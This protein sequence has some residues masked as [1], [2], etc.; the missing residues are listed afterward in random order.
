MLR[1][2]DGESCFVQDGKGVDCDDYA[3]FSVQDLLE[4]VHHRATFQL[5]L[6]CEKVATIYV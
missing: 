2:A 1:W 3:L 4:F 5:S 6:L